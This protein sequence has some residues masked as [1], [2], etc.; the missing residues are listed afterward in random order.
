MLSGDYFTTFV[1]NNATSVQHGWWCANVL[2][3]E[4]ERERGYN[5]T[6]FSIPLDNGQS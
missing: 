6:M 4:R 1:F 3:I 2:S 5:V